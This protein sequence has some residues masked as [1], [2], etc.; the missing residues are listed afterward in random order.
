M[1]V[2]G[3]NELHSRVTVLKAMAAIYNMKSAVM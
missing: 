3:P 2:V 1:A